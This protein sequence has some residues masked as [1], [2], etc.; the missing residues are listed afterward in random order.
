MDRVIL[1]KV[2]IV[3]RCLRRIADI[4]TN[5]HE[6]ETS[7]D[8]QD[9]IILNIQRAAQASIDLA[10][11][12]VRVRSLGVPQTSADAFD[13]LA[14]DKVI[15]GQLANKLKK[16]VGF[17][18]IAIHEYTKIDVAIVAHIVE[19]ELGIFKQFSQVLLNQ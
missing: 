15:E 17:R 3:D 19:D 7:Y 4:Y 11:H 6:L 10:M 13:L 9:L 18:N 16:M 12:V 8:L 2:E 14:N 1:N 5:S